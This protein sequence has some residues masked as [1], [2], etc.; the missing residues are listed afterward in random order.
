MLFRS[1]QQNVNVDLV[2]SGH[3][4]GG[5]LFPLMTIENLTKMTPD[6]RVT[7]VWIDQFL[8]RAWCTTGS[9]DSLRS[10]RPV[11]QQLLS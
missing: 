9:P 7:E 10:F 4:H 6:D 8:E 11:F 5:Q 1:A 2:F 3:T